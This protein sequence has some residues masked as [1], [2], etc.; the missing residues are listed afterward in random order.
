[1]FCIHSQMKAGVLM[2]R[3]RRAH[4]GIECAS[5][6]ISKSGQSPSSSEWPAP[7]SAIVVRETT[8]D[9]A[10]SIA[11]NEVQKSGQSAM[12]GAKLGK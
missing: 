9:E 1:M 10:K 8:L 3:L 6:K 7:Y 2:T 11:D 5:T 12:Q 4:T